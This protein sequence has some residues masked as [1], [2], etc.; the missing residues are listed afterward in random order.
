M[1][2]Q[3]WD[4][5]IR[6]CRQI[7][8]LAG[9]VV[10]SHFTALQSDPDEDHADWVPWLKKVNMEQIAWFDEW[11]ALSDHHTLELAES[12]LRW[13]QLV[14]WASLWLCCYVPLHEHDQAV[15]PLR[16]QTHG[17]QPQEVVI[18]CTQHEASQAKL[19]AEVWPFESEECLSRPQASCFAIGPES[20]GTYPT[21]LAILS[22]ES[23]TSEYR[24]LCWEPI[25]GGST[26]ATILRPGFNSK[27]CLA[28]A[29]FNS[30]DSVNPN[31]MVAVSPYCSTKSSKV[32]SSVSLVFLS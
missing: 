2:Q 31:K 7:G 26:S 4:D 23:V 1:A 5:S 16:L 3:L 20:N 10:A 21:L 11:L 24:C 13:L 27:G 22:L 28:V 29:I 12:S 8:P 18:S 14:D 17:E 30:P 19:S 6:A 9:W 32:W 15:E 25:L